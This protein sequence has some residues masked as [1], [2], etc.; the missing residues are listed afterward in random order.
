[1]AGESWPYKAFGMAVLRPSKRSQNTRY[2]Y[3]SGSGRSISKRTDL[4]VTQHDGMRASEEAA[5][6]LL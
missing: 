4:F 3:E 5:Q 2:W 6:T 1:M